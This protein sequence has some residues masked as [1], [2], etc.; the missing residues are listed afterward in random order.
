MKFSES[1]LSD[2]ID[3]VPISEVIATRVSW[4][5][6]KTRINRGD[7]WGCC[8]F[9]GET[10]PSFH[11]ENSKGRYH[12]F[13]CGVSGNHFRFL[14]ELDGVSFPRAVEMVA[15]I[16]GINLPNSGREESQSEKAE[17]LQREQQRKIKDAHKAKQAEREAER[18]AETVRSIWT[19]ARPIAGTP[20]ELYLK[21]RMIELSDFA[22]HSEWVPSLRY[23]P[24]LSFR[25]NRHNAL[26]GGVQ[27]K[28]RKIVAV[29]RIFLDQAGNPLLDENG[30][31]IKLGL[32]SASGGAVRLGPVTP[33]LKLAE[34]IET[35]LGV[36]L[37][38]KGKSSVWATL[39]TS[40]M[41]G[42]EIP[43]GVRRVEIYADGDRHRRHNNTGAV[44]E[45]PGIVAAKKLKERLLSEGIETVIYASPEPDDWLDVWVERKKDEQRQRAV[46]YS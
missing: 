41:M 46:Q 4:D 26:I 12:C 27:S 29:W 19:E 33:V 1:F 31:K 6:K 38:T 40:G 17:R 2:L 28:N 7:Y 14:M 45:P 22:E 44:V 37:L 13:G 10:R 34:G 20:A 36:M 18:K 32:G 16:A 15:S 5:R 24:S 11:C 3:R 23:H 9:H 25:G 30:K 42:I 8:P 21:S 35:A 43:D 39:S